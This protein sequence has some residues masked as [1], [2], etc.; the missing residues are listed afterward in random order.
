MAV[1]RHNEFLDAHSSED[2]EEFSSSSEAAADSRIAGLASH[3]SK[4]QKRTVELSDS[5]E[6]FDHDPQDDAAPITSPAV[7]KRPSQSSAASAASATEPTSTDLPT[8]FPK[9]RKLLTT[10]AIAAT[11]KRAHKA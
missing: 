7:A 3:R 10:S 4:R 9:K 2:N 8:D 1:R 11:N 6:D 5:D